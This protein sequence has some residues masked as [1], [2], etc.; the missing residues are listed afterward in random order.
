MRQ[1]LHLA[2]DAHV[3]PP[4]EPEERS[5]AAGWRRR[6]RSCSN[7]N[8]CAAAAAAQVA[9]AEARITRATSEQSLPVPQSGAGW[10]RRRRS[11]S[12]GAAS[13]LIAQTAAPTPPPTGCLVGSL[14][15]P[16]QL[17]LDQ[18]RR[19]STQ[20]DAV[21]RG[22]TAPVRHPTPALAAGCGEIISARLGGPVDGEGKSCCGPATRLA[23]P[24]GLESMPPSVTTN[25]TSLVVYPG[26]HYRDESEW[27]HLS[28]V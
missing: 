11:S 26:H 21:S 24:F 15:Q 13:Y 19:A 10:R 4:Q 25:S 14:S 16:T 2:G 12:S 3:G 18:L 22:S 17:A 9:P 6:R 20:E 28:W 23:R 1:G 8:V 5:Y 7:G 27:D